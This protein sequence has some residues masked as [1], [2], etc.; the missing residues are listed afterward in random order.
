MGLN[1]RDGESSP[2]DYVVS[3]IFVRPLDTAN[4]NDVLLAKTSVPEFMIPE[5]S[6][7]YPRFE[8]WIADRAIPGFLA[9][10]RDILCGFL[11]REI[12]AI[13]VVKYSKSAWTDHK[14]CSLL[15]AEQYRRWGIGSSLIGLAMERMTLRSREACVIT[16]PEERL[17]RDD[18]KGFAAFLQRS[19]FEPIAEAKARYRRAKYEVVYRCP[20]IAIPHSTHTKSGQRSIRPFERSVPGRAG[21]ERN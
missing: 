11:G 13:A 5:F 1:K 14:L 4:A 9:R 19:R 15:V 8:N 21:S 3:A 6:R 18:G 10:D 12:V 20:G 7:Y 16:V 2:E 17:V